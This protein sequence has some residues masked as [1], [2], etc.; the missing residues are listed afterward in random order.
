[1]VKRMAGNSSGQAKAARCPASAGVQH[2]LAE[3]CRAD[4][5]GRPG[6]QCPHVLLRADV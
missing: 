1:M 5:L 3:G 2:Y 4:P 6:E